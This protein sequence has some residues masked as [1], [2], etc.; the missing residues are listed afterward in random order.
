MS[1]GA[2]AVGL[3]LISLI[4]YLLGSPLGGADDPNTDTT[5]TVCAN[6]TTEEAF[7]NCM[8]NQ[9]DG[10]DFPAP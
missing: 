6:A 7:T 4:Y 10:G 1:K 9:Y 8:D 2:I 5:R 3:F